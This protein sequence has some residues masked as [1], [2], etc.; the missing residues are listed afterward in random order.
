MLEYQRTAAEINLDAIAHNI[1]EIKK[2]LK[3]ETRLLAVVKA[4]GYG[5]G[6]VETAQICLYNGAD[7]LAVATFDEGVALRNNNIFVPILILGYTV[8][9]RLEDVVLNNLT[10]TVFSYELAK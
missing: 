10:Q 7:E 6:A 5:H 9:N 4:D 3:P 8:E 2:R 1:K